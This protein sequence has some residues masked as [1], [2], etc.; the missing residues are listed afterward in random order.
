MK[1]RILISLLT[2]TICLTSCTSYDFS[3]HVVQ[4]GN[5]L[6]E[7]KIKR[8]KT[9]MSKKDVAI[10]MGSSLLSPTFDNNRWD[11]AY[12][13]RRGNQRNKVRNL[14]LFFRHGTLIKIKH[15]P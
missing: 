4:Q 14:R 8:L 5:L 7:S 12:T 10:L 9:G 2:L 15:Y 6:P 1:T 11:Y 3:R 13:Y